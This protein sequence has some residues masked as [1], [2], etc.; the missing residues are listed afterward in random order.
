MTEHEQKVQ[1]LT[2]DEAAAQLANQIELLRTVANAVSW[3]RNFFAEVA[4]KT[5]PPVPPALKGKEAE[6]TAKF[7]RMMY[8]LLLAVAE[9]LTAGEVQRGEVHQIPGGQAH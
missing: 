7:V 9:E 1:T 2:A 4:A 8:D 3:N 6:L 5:M